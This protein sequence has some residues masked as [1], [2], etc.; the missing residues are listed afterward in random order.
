MTAQAAESSSLT[1][2]EIYGGAD[3]WSWAWNRIKYTLRSIVLLGDLNLEVG[4]LSKFGCGELFD[5]DRE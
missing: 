4:L 2:F 5:L 1:W 3:A